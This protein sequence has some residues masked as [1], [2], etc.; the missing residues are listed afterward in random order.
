[1]LVIVSIHLVVPAFQVILQVR[2]STC[3][4]LPDIG[5]TT[6]DLAQLTA[7]QRVAKRNGVLRGQLQ[8]IVSG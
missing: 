2:S 4:N 1:M 7:I 3:R 8:R 5:R 6:N